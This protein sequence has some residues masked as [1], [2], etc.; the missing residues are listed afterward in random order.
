MEEGGRRDLQVNIVELVKLEEKR[1]GKFCEG[2]V[3]GASSEANTIVSDDQ[4][5]NMRRRK[6]SADGE[7][8]RQ[9][10]KKKKL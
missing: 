8:R 6:N 4:P 9:N 3:A 1:R 2:G 10:K 7:R 5:D